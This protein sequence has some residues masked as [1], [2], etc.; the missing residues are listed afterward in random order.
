MKT[1]I[2]SFKIGMLAT[3]AALAVGCVSVKREEP[4]SSTTVTHSTSIAPVG[5]TTTTTY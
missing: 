3:V 4:A 2:L 5:T 1:L